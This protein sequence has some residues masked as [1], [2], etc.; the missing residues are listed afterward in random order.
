MTM[1]PDAHVAALDQLA[2]HREQVAQLDAREAAHFATLTQR[3]AEITDMVAAIGRTLPDSTAALA[4]LEALDQQVTDLTAQLTSSPGADGSYQPDPPPA[5]WKLTGTEREQP[6]ARL[7]AWTEQVYRPGYG[8]LAAALSPCWESHDLCLYALD[9]LSQLWSALYLQ[10]ERTM[11]VLS[12]QAEYQ[13]RLLPA[14][15]EQMHTETS[16]CGHPQTRPPVPGQA[17]SAP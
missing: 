12:A 7:R 2:A 11:A 13:A 3:L 9:I 8:R 1:T 6:L 15:A 14:L 4:R 16:R 5:W 17:R 10:P